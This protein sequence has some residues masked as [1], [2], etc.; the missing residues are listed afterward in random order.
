MVSTTRRTIG[1]AR[2]RKGAEREAQSTS[3]S[4]EL[5]LYHELVGSGKQ[6]C[7]RRWPVHHDAVRHLSHLRGPLG[8]CCR[9]SADQV[10]LCAVTY[11]M[12]LD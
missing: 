11:T 7:S 4:P 6:C 10:A 3:K 8:C 5:E 2:I 12:C 1:R 9:D